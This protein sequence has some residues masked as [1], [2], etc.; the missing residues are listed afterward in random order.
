MDKDTIGQSMHGSQRGLRIAQHY[1]NLHMRANTHTHTMCIAE[2]M[3]RHPDTQ[4]HTHIYAHHDHMQRKHITSKLPYGALLCEP[5][6]H[7][8]SNGRP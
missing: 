2:L 4:T 3:S 5:M 7:T 8:A 6:H 1:V